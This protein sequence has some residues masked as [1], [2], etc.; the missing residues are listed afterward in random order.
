MVIKFKE[1]E[2]STGASPGAVTCRYNLKTL[3]INRRQTDTYSDQ[4]TVTPQQ[5]ARLKD[6]KASRLEI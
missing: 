3:K 6:K 1:L 2:I 4:Q 5:G